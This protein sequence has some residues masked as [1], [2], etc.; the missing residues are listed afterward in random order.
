MQSVSKIICNDNLY[1]I[2][3]A[4]LYNNIDGLFFQCSVKFFFSNFFSI[5]LLLILSHSFLLLGLFFF[6]KFIFCSIIVM[7]SMNH[8]R[9]YTI[10]KYIQHF[11]ASVIDSYSEI[12]L[13][14]ISSFIKEKSITY[15][16]KSK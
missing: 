6:F 2:L 9:A 1:Y 14:Q 12:S 16:F 4:K 3:F 13:T 7:M 8:N 5:Q 10:D 15:G 11:S